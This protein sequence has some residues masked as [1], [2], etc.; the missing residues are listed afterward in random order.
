M[1]TKSIEPLKSFSMDVNNGFQLD[2]PSLS[3]ILKIPETNRS[4]EQTKILASFLNNLNDQV[5]IIIIKIS[6][7]YI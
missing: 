3:P 4:I 2:I 5:Y 1:L 6:Q 7:K